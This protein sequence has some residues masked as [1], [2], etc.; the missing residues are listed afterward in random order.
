MSE[1]I[2]HME[3]GEPYITDET[4]NSEIV[5]SVHAPF[6]IHSEWVE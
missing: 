3:V 6:K 2:V 5:L 1:L 4:N